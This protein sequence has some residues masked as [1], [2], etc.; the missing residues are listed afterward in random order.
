[1]QVW[2]AVEYAGED[3]GE[4]DVWQGHPGRVVDVH[5]TDVSV[6]WVNGPSW[7]LPEG[8][9]R[10]LTESEYL[11]RGDRVISRRHPLRDQPISGFNVSGHEWP[12]GHRPPG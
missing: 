11:A 9:L 4:N 2:Q 12:D 8:N 10:P 7:E 5:L 1:M 3:D 6:S